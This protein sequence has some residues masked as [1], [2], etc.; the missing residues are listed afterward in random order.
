MKTNDALSHFNE[1]VRE[2][3]KA[4]DITV[5][6]VYSWGETVPPLRVYQIR[7]ILAARDKAGASNTAPEPTQKAA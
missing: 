3:A 1:S 7:E 4:L 6:A 5:Q 2:L